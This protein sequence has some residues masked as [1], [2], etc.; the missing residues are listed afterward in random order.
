AGWET[1]AT[2]YRRFFIGRASSTPGARED[3]H[4]SQAGSTAI[5]QVGKPAL[6]GIADFQSAG[7]RAHRARGK[8]RTVRRLEALRYS[9]LGNL[10]YAVSPIFN[11]QGVEHTGRAGRFARF[12]GWKHCDTA[13]WETCATLYRRFSIGR[14]SST[15]GARE[16]SHDS[17]AGSTAIQQV[18]KPALRGIADF[19]SAGRRAH[20]ARGKIRTVR[21]L[22]A[23]RYSRLGNLRYAVSPI[24]NRPGV[25]H[26][27][28][29]G[30]FA[31]FAGWKHCDTAGWETC[32]TL[33]R[34][35]SIGRASSTPGAR[36]D[37]HDSQAGSTAIQQVGKPAL[38]GIAD[39]LSAGRRAHRARG[40]IRTVRRLEALR[41]SRLGNL[42]YA[43]SPIFN[44][45]GV[46]HTG[47]AGRFARFAGWKHCD[48][49]GWETC[50]TLYRRFSI[51]RASSTPGARED[52]HDSQAGSTAIQQVGKPALRGI[53]DFLSAGR[54]AHRARGKIRTVRRLEALRYSRLGNLRYA[55]SP[56]F[57]RPGVEHTGRAGRFAR[58]AGWKHCDTAGWE[59]CATLYRRFSIGRASSTPGA[60]EDSHDSQAG[61]TAIQQV[62]KPALR[63]IADFL[64]AGR[65][66]HR[67]RGKIRTVRRL[68]ALRYSRLGNLRYAV[69]PIFNR[70]GVEHT[71]R[72]GRFARFAGWK[73]CDTAGWETCATLY[74]RFSIGR[75]SSTPGAREDS[76]DSQ[77]GSTAIQQVGKPALRGIADF[78]SAGRRAHRA[79]GKIRTVRRLE[80]LRYS[81]LGNLRYAVSPIFNRPG[82]EHTGRAGR[83]ARFAGWKHCDTAGW[84]TC[85]TLYRRF[86]IGR[87]SSTPGAREDSHDSQ[88]GSTAIQQVGKPALRGIADF[89]SA[90]R[91]A[92]RAR[93][94]IRT[95]RRL[96]ALRYSRL[97][98][99]RYAVSPIFNRPGVEHTGR[100][101]RFARF[102]GWKH[103]DTAGWE[104]CATLYRRF[105]IGRASST[106][107]A[108]ED[109]HDSQAG[110]T[111]IQQVG[112][113]ALRCIADF[114][115][116]GRRAHRA[117]GKIRTI[118]RLEALRYSRLGN[119]RYAV[120][121]IF[122]RPGVEHTGRAGRFAR[123]AGWKHCDTAG[124]E[125]CATLYRRFSIGRASST[126]GAR[127][128]SHD[129]QAGS[130][131]IQQVGKPALRYIADFQSA[132]RRAHGAR[133]KIRTIRRLE[134]LR[135]SRLGNL[136]YAI[137]P[138]FNRPG[139]EHT[140]R[141]GRFARF[142]GWKHC[143]TAG[144]ETCAT[145]YR[146]FSIGRA[147]STPGAREDSHGS[148]AG[149]TAI[150]QVGKPA[151]RY[152]AD[153]Q[154]AGRRAHGA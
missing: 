31:R 63:G 86:S 41:Y 45:P 106:P 99:L 17:Q 76:H 7:R 95:V 137:S 150:Q 92:H 132:G 34:R 4:G 110:S 50:A 65:R 134:A 138:I 15:P 35:F 55:V 53:A 23:L 40:K 2:R 129:S 66:A 107:G 100:A 123:F 12:A 57:N 5:Q 90:G 6:R 116:A 62:G 46:E 32:A 105:S 59:T 98:N 149:S 75:A 117:R 84:E 113:P 73:H 71:G 139:V 141:A 37:S 8:I 47:R 10:R 52:S 103:C 120:S 131:A 88:A 68:E 64:S 14:A 49:A 83:F 16:D 69:S 111:A 1:C 142:A 87:A 101:G 102:A 70:P 153:F 143:D 22:E 27:G 152:I 26:T 39:F 108:R 133:G 29:A 127:E 130:T 79:R 61:S 72:A 104:T 56:I 145:L 85:A 144:W 96:E 30:R 48:T 33:Y 114:Q 28:R 126:R 36:E 77:A 24:F 148:Q 118:R 122:N 97:G 78:L 13:G 146:R 147:S 25:E 67:A 60:R 135:Y 18:G 44:R 43:V 94:K 9:R 54:R 42:R 109:S 21:R 20:R 119:L 89:L 93:G 151:L 80:A 51:G 3:S 125:T 115:S 82:V 121:P 58:F 136:R 81:R 124:W 74:R 140:G 128:D 11:R 38:R 19:L 112:K 91:R 154:S